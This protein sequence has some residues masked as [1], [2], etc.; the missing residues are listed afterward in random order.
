MY[1]K[2]IKAAEAGRG[3][4]L[5]DRPRTGP[6]EI[7]GVPRRGGDDSDRPARRDPP[8]RVS[9]GDRRETARPR[10]APRSGL[11]GGG[12][13][14]SDDDGLD[15]DSFEG[16]APRVVTGRRRFKKAWKA[17]P[18]QSAAKKPRSPPVKNVALPPLDD[19][20]ELPRATHHD[21][22]GHD[23]LV[24]T[25][26]ATSR[27]YRDERR[28]ERALKVRP[29]SRELVRAPSPRRAAPDAAPPHQSRSLRYALGGRQEPRDIVEPPKPASPPPRSR[30]PRPS[31]RESSPPSRPAFDPNVTLD[32]RPL[33]GGDRRPRTHFE[34]KGFSGTFG[35]G[36]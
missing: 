8:P 18:P 1:Y 28:A 20:G 27:R 35:R 30:L 11:L 10:R 19:G 32:H 5:I 22:P 25:A 6:A 24:A 12:S 3:A 9:T 14:F 31:P 23:R 13:L 36:Y 7:V 16:G 2:T 4:P 33:L 29:I 26:A 15:A 34:P 21:G 17:P